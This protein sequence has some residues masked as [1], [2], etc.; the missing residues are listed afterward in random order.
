MAVPQPTR[1]R[2]FCV[3]FALLATLCC[4][5]V[6]S[7]RAAN[8]SRAHHQ[9]F[10]SRYCPRCALLIGVG[11]TYWPWRWTDGIVAP[12]L[13]ELDQSRWELGA[14]RFATPQYLKFSRFPPS[15]ISAHPYWGFSAMRRWQVLHR[16]RWKVYVGFGAVY[17]SET[18]LLE[19]IRWNFAYL[20]SLR[21]A[22][23]QNTFLEFS[24]RHW[25]DAWIKNP[26]RG[27]N[28]VLLSIGLH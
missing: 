24:V 26:D 8:H 27:Q 25:S 11:T 4:R 28:F 20:V 7:A 10:A 19:P 6:P 9:W 1:D 3:L 21:Y 16:S 18:D 14:F 17:R 23:R 5:A 12:V 15:T 13:L 2:T 22:L